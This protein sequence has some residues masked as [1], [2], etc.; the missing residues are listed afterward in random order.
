MWLLIELIAAVA[1]ISCAV[2]FPFPF[3]PVVG[4]V[5]FVAV[6]LPNVARR[7]SRSRL[8]VKAYENRAYKDVKC[9]KC[10]V[11]MQYYKDPEGWG[12]IPHAVR[13][14]VR[15]K[16]WFRPRQANVR[17]CPHCAGSGHVPKEMYPSIGREEVAWPAP[18]DKPLWADDKIEGD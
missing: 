6:T 3:G 8:T 13:M 10:T 11:G 9:K 17:S 7:L 18:D 15:G 14:V 5:A 4:I 12:P 2:A 1:G 16:D